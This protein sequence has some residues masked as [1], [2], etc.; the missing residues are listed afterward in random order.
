M[1]LNTILKVSSPQGLELKIDKILAGLA[2]AIAQGKTI[3]VDGE[4]LTVDE[5]TKKLAAYKP[6]FADPRVMRATLRNLVAARKGVTPEVSRFLNAL[7]AGLICVLGRTNP[8]LETLGYPPRK[9]NRKLTV[10][11]KL[12]KAAAAAATRKERKT[13]GPRQKESIHGEPPA[14]G[15]AAPKSAP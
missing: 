12:Q 14:T 2:G 15:G 11:E 10:E 7:G 9:A 8:V 13:L 3:D 1:S 6:F 4:T 5:I